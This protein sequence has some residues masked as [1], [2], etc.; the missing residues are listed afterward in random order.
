MVAETIIFWLVNSFSYIGIFLAS[1]IVSISIVFPLPGLL[2]ITWAVV[3]NL[4][5][6]FVSIVSASGSMIG[7]LTGYYAGVLG[8]KL[9]E[10]TV[11]K[12]KKISKFLRKYFTKYAVIIIFLAAV[13]PFPF[14]LVGIIAG[15]SR[16]SLPKFLIFG[17]AGKF[18]KTLLLFLALKY[19]ISFI[20]N[21]WKIA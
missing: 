4:N 1:F 10:K 11:K 19:S 20:I 13:L 12:Y 5:P 15:A 16:Y 18:F 6:I 9:A 2:V 21:I 14:D 7:E 8:N 17:T 3:M